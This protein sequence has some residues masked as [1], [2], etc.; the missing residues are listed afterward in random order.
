MDVRHEKED[1]LCRPVSSR[2]HGERSTGGDIDD[3]ASV[4]GVSSR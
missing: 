4:L 2:T 3:Y 1:G